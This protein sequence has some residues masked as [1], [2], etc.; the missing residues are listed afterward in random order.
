MHPLNVPAPIVD[1]DQLSTEGKDGYLRS[2]HATLTEFADQYDYSVKALQYTHFRI[3]GDERVLDI[4]P[5]NRK[6]HDVSENSRGFY[7]HLP[8]YLKWYFGKGTEPGF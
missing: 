1:M 4:C 8:G 3:I 6:H 5:V 2:V 7:G